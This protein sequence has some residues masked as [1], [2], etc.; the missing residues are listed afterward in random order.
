MP[1]QQHGTTFTRAR[2][3]TCPGQGGPVQKVLEVLLERNGRSLRDPERVLDVDQEPAERLELDHP[4]LLLVDVRPLARLHELPDHD[5][6]E[7]RHAGAAL[8]VEEGV[9]DDRDHD[10]Q[11]DVR[12]QHHERDEEERREQRLAA[13]IWRLGQHAGEVPAPAVDQA[14]VRRAAARGVRGGH[15]LPARSRTRAKHGGGG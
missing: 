9:E 15:A 6:V 4:V 2:T 7:Q 14:A 8:D 11:A 5:L 3:H 1:R 10:V 13:V 12:G